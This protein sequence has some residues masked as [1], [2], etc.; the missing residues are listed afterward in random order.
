MFL[1]LA[2]SLCAVLCFDLLRGGMLCGVVCCEAHSCSLGTFRG[3]W[4]QEGRGVT[5][6]GGGS[7]MRMGGN[8]QK[9]EEY[10]TF[11]FSS[12]AIFC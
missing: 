4:G 2:V 12:N 3:A 10:E 11:D 7:M 5:R 8:I 1:F 6:R 9:G